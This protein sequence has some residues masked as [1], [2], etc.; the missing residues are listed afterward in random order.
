MF[1]V[2]AL[3]DIT[4]AFASAFDSAAEALT[5]VA[6]ALSYLTAA[7]TVS[8]APTLGNKRRRFLHGNSRNSFPLPKNPI[9]SIDDSVVTKAIQPIDMGRGK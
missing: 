7:P 2:A 1:P 9:Q 8:L 5:V 6:V 4:F 3:I